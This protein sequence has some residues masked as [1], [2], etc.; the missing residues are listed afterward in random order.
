M[1]ASG[2]DGCLAL[3]QMTTRTT[4]PPV[5]KATER[6]AARFGS[7]RPITI[8]ANTKTTAI[9]RTITYRG[10]GRPMFSNR[11]W[12]VGIW[13]VDSGSHI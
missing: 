4:T 10:P 1:G 5:N 2:W 8:A 7:T 6:I 11:S 3:R 12:R 13:E 9:A